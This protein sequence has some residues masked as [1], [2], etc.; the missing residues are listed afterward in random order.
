M[1]IG[2]APDA[3]S[4]VVLTAFDEQAFVSAVTLGELAFGAELVRSAVKRARGRALIRMVSDILPCL[5]RGPVEA[6]GA[7]IHPGEILLEEFLKPLDLNAH[8]LAQAIRVPANRITAILHGARGVSAET[9]LRLARYFDTTP[10]FWL[11]LQQMYE[12]RCAEQEHGKV[13]AEEVTPM[14]RSAL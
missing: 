7:A 5:R 12:L 11:N 1:T 10:D 8:R 3:Q 4:Q 9:A 6:A 14:K 13:I 2:G